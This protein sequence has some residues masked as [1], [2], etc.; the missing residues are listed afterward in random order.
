M[1]KMFF[2]RKTNKPFRTRR[3]RKP[4]L[5]KRIKL[6]FPKLVFIFLFVFLL[7]GA[8]FA[9][10]YYE[11]ALL[12]FFPKDKEEILRPTHSL[13]TG[14]DEVEKI[15]SERG[16]KFDDIKLSS[17]SPTLS[18]NL[19]DYGV[20]V[21]FS[22]TKDANWQVSSLQ[23]ILKRITIDKERVTGGSAESVID[24]R[25]DRPIVK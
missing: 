23:Q 14:E 21:I 7:G 20:R 18:V 1:K 16:L 5:G 19:S 12:S 17:V 6:D 15:L 24:F 4:L 8:V 2:H 13:Y 11:D 9:Y 3:N 10:K 25:L 22:F